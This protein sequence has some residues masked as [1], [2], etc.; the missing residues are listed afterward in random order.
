MVA[1]GDQVD[2]LGQEPAD[3]GGAAVEVDVAEEQVD[4][5]GGRRG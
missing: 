5:R 4:R 1:V 3:G 2:L